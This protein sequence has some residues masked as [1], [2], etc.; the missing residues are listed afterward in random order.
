MAS[1]SVKYIFDVD[2]TLTPSRGQMDKEFRKWFSLFAEGHE[3]YLVT[4]SD[5]PKTLEQIGEVIYNRV[6]RVYQCGGNDVWQDTTKLYT[7]TFTFDDDLR[8]ALEAEIKNSKF[9]YKVGKH[10]EERDGLVNLSIIGRPAP[11]QERVMYRQWDEHK[12][13]RQEIVS[14]LSEQFDKYEFKVAGETGIDI[15]MAG[16]SKAQILEDFKD[17]DVIWFFGDKTLVGG[18]DHEIALA[19]SDRLGRNKVFT[20]SE[21]RHTWNILKNS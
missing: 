21:W 1:E 12:N 2:G 16:S 3:V 13:E 17:T 11:M 14:R 8:E 15:T 19:V 18:N 4:G 9:Y 10:I 20:V 7:R 5:R 6:K